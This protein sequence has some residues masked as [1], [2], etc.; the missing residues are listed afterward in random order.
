MI[1]S[2]MMVVSVNFSDD[3]CKVNSL[4]SRSCRSSRSEE[5][6]FFQPEPDRG[7]EENTQGPSAGLMEFASDYSYPMCCFYSN[8]SG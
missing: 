2:Q 5:Q 1:R 6:E 7:Q 8:D 3:T 4:F